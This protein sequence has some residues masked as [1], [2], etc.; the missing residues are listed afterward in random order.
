MARVL[1]VDDQA[2]FRQ[3]LRALL[4]TEP[5][6]EIVGE[7]HD[8]VE[9]LR[10]V[11]VL[12]PDV[13][14]LDLRMPT[15]GGVETTRRLKQLRP[16]IQVVVLTTFDEDELMFEALKEGAL[17]YLLKDATAD[18]IANAIRAAAEGRSILAR[19]V[20][21]KFVS[22]FARMARL[23]GPE[24]TQD[25]GLSK[26]ELDVL[27]H[28]ARGSSNKEIGSALRIAEGTVK[29]HLTNI[30]GKLEVS[31]RTQAAL[32]ARSRGLV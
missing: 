1:L 13:V 9:C 3:G 29:N 10:T 32:L 27:R 20:A 5:G 7:A 19:S 25:L 24:H 15:M 21:H 12:A 4:S 28:I 14:L 31:D 23:I 11:G 8:G 26:R 2:S 22:E 30:F 6:I 18:T 17:S 16:E